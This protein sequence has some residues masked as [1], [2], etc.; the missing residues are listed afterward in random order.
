MASIDDRIVQMQFDNAAFERKLATTIESI[1]K[2]DKSIQNVGT[3]NGLEQVSQSA[4][5]FHLNPIS[6]AIESVSGKFLAMSAIAV[7][8]LA[9]ITS[10]AVAAGA[11]LVKALAIDPII[12][13]YK[14]YELQIQSI[15]TILSNTAQDGTNLE[16]VSA[17]LDEL[18]HY[19]D[20]T[21]YNFSEMTRNIGMFTAAGVDLDTSVQSI[22][23]IANLAAISGSNSQQASTAMYQLSQAISTG[24]V[25]LMDWNSVVNAGMGGKVFQNALFETGKMMGTIADV[26]MGQ[27]FEEW[28]D[29]GNTFRGSLQDGWLTAEVLTTTLQ[30]FTGELTKAQL[31]S[32]G[33]TE[34]QA[35]MFEQL[36]TMG[37]DAATKVR[38]LTQLLQTT[39]EAISSGWSES[40]RLIV[41]DFEEATELWSGISDSIGG[42]VGKMSDARNELIQGW[43]DLGGRERL[44]Q[45]LKTGFENLGKVLH[46]IGS[47]FREVFPPLTAERLMELT[48]AF[49]DFM[50][51]L[52]PSPATLV[53]VRHIF[54]GFFSVLKIGWTVISEGIGF[55]AGLVKALLG[56]G[57]GKLLGGLA[58]IADF[59]TDLR[60]KLVDDGGIKKFFDGLTKAVQGPVEFIRQ[61]IGIIGDLF[62]TIT[63]GAGDA[64]GGAVDRISD[65]F[66][67]LGD[68]LSNIAEPL[69]R[70]FGRLG[71]ILGKAWEQISKWLSELGDKFAEAFS[72]GDFN[73]ALDTINTA[74]LGGIVLLLRNFM[75]NGLGLNLDI[76]GGLFG[77]IKSSFEELTGVL[78]AMQTNLKAEALMKIAIAIGILTASLVV[79]SMIDSAALTRA[80]AAMAVGFGQLIG[81]FALLNKAGFSTISAAKLGILA[82]GLILLAGA[83]VI[84]SAAVKILG[85]MSWGEL[86]KGLVGVT[87]LLAVLSAASI[88]LSKNSA[89]MFRVGLGLVAVAI[90][91]NL[92]A[93][94]VKSFAEMSWE[95]MGKGMAAVATGLLIMAGAMRLMPKGMALQG[96]GLLLVAASLRILANAV[97]AFAGLS[98]TQLG[99]G[100]VGV[101]GGLLVIGLAMKLMPATM[102]LIGAGLLLVSASLILIAK[103]MESFGGMSWG[104]IAKGV[105]AMG[106][107]LLVLALGAHAMSGAVAGAIGIAILAA[108]ML[109]LVKVIKELAQL[110]IAQIVTALV[111]LAAA[112]AV[113]AAV[114][115]AIMATGAIAA[116]LALGVA[117]VLLGAGLALAGVGILSLAKALEILAR[118]GG[119][120]ITFLLEL[121]DELIL[122]IPTLMSQ[123]A[124]GMLEMVQTFIDGLPVLVEALKLLLLELL[125][126]II[127]VM[128][129]IGEALTAIF[130]MLIETIRGLFPQLVQL[131]M[132]LI[133]ALLTGI[134]DNIGEIVTVALEV[135]TAFLGGLTDNVAM[136]IA[137]VVT[138][139][140]A[141]IDGVAQN[142]PRIIDSAVNLLVKFLSGITNNLAK[143]ATAVVT[144]ITT[145]LNTIVS[146]HSRIVTAGVNALIKFLSGI[147]D[148]LVKVV[149]AVTTM[150]TKFITAVGDAA[151][152][153]A[154]AGTDALVDFLE[155]MTNN[156]QKIVTAV[157]TMITKFI[158]AVGNEAQRIITAG[159]DMIIDL[160]TGIGEAAADIADAAM[161]T[162]VTFVDSLASSVESHS[163][164]L[165][166]A[167]TRLVGAIIDGM[168]FG[169]A[170]KV[171]RVGQSIVGGLRSAVGGVANFLGIGSPSKL[172]MEIGD[173]MMEGMAVGIEDNTNPEKQ[174][175]AQVKSLTDSVQSKLKDFNAMVSN[176]EAINPTITPILDL[177]QV[178][179]DAKTISSLFPVPDLASS[180]AYSQAQTIARTSTPVEDETAAGTTSGGD[181]V[182]NQTINAPEQLSTADIYKQTRNQITMAKEELKIP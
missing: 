168:T 11:Q 139:I 3:K 129:K 5:R 147:T 153:I 167:G 107:A 108:S 116:L 53:K 49:G 104:E 149:T 48:R 119:A 63:G 91:L 1:G 57:E 78:S 154:K 66:S 52:T 122:R 84:L 112:L 92:L 25:K 150:V 135:L 26:P 106:A 90:A 24:S 140:T 22:K 31:V 174:A 62:E 132:D 73:K 124:L 142:L 13:G 7:T 148:N 110:S 123:L 177:T 120:A 50:Q 141:Y 98:W 33:Y 111:T 86:I 21:I 9:T 97:E 64:A 55:I 51:K 113:L 56:V 72:E 118:T 93:L 176:I 99:K 171:A 130:E 89:G 69:G 74:F 77:S 172:F 20:K 54:E 128:P 79:L 44:I 151:T 82:G 138:L 32:L 27:S 166:S 180:L 85:S 34:E 75:K 45:G 71:E 170:G 18:N 145:L 67:N 181:V 173:L 39:K 179:R 105:V 19:A 157:G 23:G 182:F 46:V 15:Q 114:A 94:A 10:K 12:D 61:L 58:K 47:A 81:A 125:Q 68:T 41:G 80:L 65:R 146:L 36:G 165:R 59:F 70:V 161:D 40:F 28:T 96:V 76:G 155:G 35:A 42:F 87:V 37:V 163:G 117:I 162:V 95:E 2:L 121:A 29:A 144:M 127:E 14:E 43:R 102:P 164:E 4:S 160:I 115:Y 30:G 83:M 136:V 175:V 178:Q 137:A 88:V 16:Q 6:T 101:G 156:L 17:A 100:L 134:R 143:V 131:G 169:L 133:I 103:A 126:M 159:T 8:A 158:T 152:R 60:E 109:V 38:T